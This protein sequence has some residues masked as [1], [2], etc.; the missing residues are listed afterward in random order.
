[1]CGR[2]K[3][4]VVATHAHSLTPKREVTYINSHGPD[5]PTGVAT[6]DNVQDG[7]DIDVTVTQVMKGQET[8]DI[9]ELTPLFQNWDRKSKP[10]QILKELCKH[11]L[12]KLDLR[13]R[14]AQS[15]AKVP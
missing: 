8:K 5:D 14:L 3:H 4:A 1:M 6:A 10:S 11:V 7:W 12:E 9:P 2:D 13:D 15:E